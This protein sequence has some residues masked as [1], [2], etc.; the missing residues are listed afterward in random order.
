MIRVLGAAIGFT[1]LV[2]FATGGNKTAIYI[3]FFGALGVYVF[4]LLSGRMK[5]RCPYCHKRVKLGAGTCHHCGRD[6][7]AA[8]Q[9]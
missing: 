1:I 5:L 8:R 3:A 4:A 7:I 6:V 2:S 9:P